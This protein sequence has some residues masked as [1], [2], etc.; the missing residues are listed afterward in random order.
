MYKHCINPY[1]PYIATSVYN[2]TSIAK[3]SVVQSPRWHNQ[4][5]Q[6]THHDTLLLTTKLN[7]FMVFLQSYRKALLLTL[8]L[9]LPFILSA[10]SSGI[11]GVV[12]DEAGEPYIGATVMVR[13]NTLATITDLDGK[14]SL[15]V[16]ENA[17]LV[18]SYIGCE[19]ATVVAYV[20]RPVT[21]VLKQDAVS[22]DAG[23]V[24]AVGYGT[25]KKES[26]VAAISTIRPGELRAPVRS[27][28]QSLAGNVAGLV[29]LQSSGEPGKD[30]AQFWIRGIATFTGDPNPLV[31]VDGIERPLENV[32]PLEIESFSVL[33]DASATAVYG[34]RGANG[35]IIIN[36]RRGFDGPARIDVR[37]EQGFSSPSKRLS[38]VGP[39]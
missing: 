38:F 8:C 2:L 10:Q 22:L 31:L 14:F 11:S 35:V 17:T 30:D 20:G 33:K 24:V 7:Y 5:Q 25:Q 15:D 36:T 34:V 6:A 12:I 28:S 29:A 23:E 9:T 3:Q 18:V 21:V 19:T 26:V 32:D 1:Y 4:W 16:S 37:Y 13:G 27:L 39:G